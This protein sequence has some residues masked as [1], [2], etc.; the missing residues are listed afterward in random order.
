M[1]ASPGGTTLW[2]E[3]Q[4][5]WDNPHGIPSSNQIHKQTAERTHTRQWQRLMCFQTYKPSLESPSRHPEYR[6][7]CRRMLHSWDIMLRSISER[8]LGRVASRWIDAHIQ[9]DLLNNRFIFLWLKKMNTNRYLLQKSPRLLFPSG[10]MA[11]H[12]AYLGY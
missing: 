10:K 8:R 4:S 9:R 3:N 11:E 1:P 6:C 12:L 5:A 2:G 7:W